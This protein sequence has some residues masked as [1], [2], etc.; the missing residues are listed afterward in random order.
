MESSKTGQRALLALSFVLVLATA[1]AYWW[2]SDRSGSEMNRWV[3]FGQ[4]SSP[5][6]AESDRTLLSVDPSDST[7]LSDSPLTTEPQPAPR[8]SQLAPSELRPAGDVSDTHSAIASK[9]ALPEDS[10]DRGGVPGNGAGVMRAS[11]LS[12]P[13]TV[14]QVEPEQGPDLR[15]SKLT[16]F[17]PNQDESQ[18]P[19]IN[20][21]RQPDGLRI[22][23]N[24]V[25][26]PPAMPTA[27]STSRG[28]VISYR[29]VLSFVHDVKIVAQADGVIREFYVDEG[30]VVENDAVI[31]EIDNRLAKAE[32]EVAKKEL[33][34]AILKAEDESQ[35]KFSV[36]SEEVAKNDFERTESLFRKE[37]ANVDEYERKRLEWIKAGFQIEVSKREQKINQSA[38]GVSQAKVNASAVQVELRTI[39]APFTGIVAKTD[40]ERF[41]WVKA[42]DEIMRLV[43]LDSFRVKGRVRISESPNILERAPARVYIQIRPGQVEQ[44]DGVVGFVE[45]ETQGAVDGK[46]EFAVW[47]EIPNRIV[48]GQYLFRGKMDATVEITPKQ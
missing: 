44:V 28:G 38:V 47:V 31:V 43:S 7:N 4:S 23:T 19:V 48:G 8:A 16:T 1:G 32:Q 11:M 46:N 27:E 15:P 39:R 22:P 17:A 34:S 41:E 2:V 37:V 33:E 20:P 29:G 9:I 14:E 5:A 30:S 26:V 21:Q 36:A 40:K 18:S 35:I 25:P 13:Q 6:E 45:P 3:S 42:G 24:G 10:L 12:A